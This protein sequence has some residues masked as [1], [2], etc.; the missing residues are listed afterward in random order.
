MINPNLNWSEPTTILILLVL[1]ALLLMQIW[2][3][4]RNR[5]IGSGRKGVRL[6]LNLVLWLLLVGF[7]V[8]PRWKV[9]SGTTHTLIAGDDVP[10]AYLRQLK[11]SLSIQETYSPDDV[12]TG[13]FTGQRFDQ[14]TLVGQ[15]IDAE[16]LSQLSRHRLRWIPYDAPDQVQDVRWKGVV[17]KGDMQ[18]ISGHILSTRKQW[19]K[20]TYG[21]RTLDSL[22]LR[23]GS[24]AFSL[25]FPT[26]STGRTI[27]ELVLDQRVLDTL[28]FFAQPTEPLHYQFILGS[29]DF[30]SKTLA[31]WLGKQGHSV[32]VSTTLSK[33][34]TGSL[35]INAKI[36]K[37]DVVITDPDHAGHAV[38]KRAVAEGKSVLFINLSEPVADVAAIN[39]TLGT[40]WKLRKL[41][42]EPYIPVGNSLNALPYT[43]TQAMNQVMIPGY[44]AAVQ[45]IGG[46]VGLS[47]L[48]ETFPLQLS[49]DST[50][51]D[52]IW[53]TLLNPLR[54]AL[55]NN[56]QI[57]A[58]VFTRFP[59]PIR[60]NNPVAP[61]AAVRIAADTVPVQPSP[62]NGLTTRTAY[63]FRNPGWQVWQDSLEV[64]I[65]G[66]TGFAYQQ[67]LISHYLKAHW[68]YP[69]PSTA[70]VPWAEEKIP[71]WVWLLLLLTAFTALWVEPK[72]N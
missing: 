50:A 71:N 64:Y 66:R 49:G 11:D 4:V 42:N 59:T 20:I 48:S 60:I 31:D 43:P 58:P 57:E 22:E 16:T 45:R 34:I 15:D 17:R 62:L 9:N 41:S 30:E 25:R 33:N 5:T 38:V 36:S 21:N 26:F 32:Q 54:P 18:R 35:Q 68:R 39:R 63:R 37:P 3:I 56:V 29:P 27:T 8:Q 72:I 13:E 14:V 69:A 10:D 46:N 40:S 28:R 70:V 12:K 53:S 47:L 51:Y 55:R 1:V 19:L 65:N 24:N 7:V 23:E 61:I 44:P 6:A 52:R 2:L 67:A